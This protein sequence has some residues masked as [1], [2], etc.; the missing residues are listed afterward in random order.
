MNIPYSGAYITQHYGKP[1]NQCYNV[2]IE[3]NRALYMDEE[4]IT[5]NN[6]FTALQHSL[7]HVMAAIAEYVTDKVKPTHDRYIAD[8]A[9]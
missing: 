9:E 8:A 2:Q 1:Q 7:N 6:N 3:I 4:N 5:K